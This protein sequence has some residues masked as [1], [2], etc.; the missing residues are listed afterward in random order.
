MQTTI[1]NINDM[2]CMGCVNSIKNVIEEISG[3]SDAEVSL[4]SK[5]LEIQYDPEKVNINQ[6]KKAIMEAG[7]EINN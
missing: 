6:I 4:E 2:T 5:Q 1:L 7:F 3:V